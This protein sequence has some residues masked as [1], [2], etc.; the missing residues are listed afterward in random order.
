MNAKRG[1]GQLL[2]NRARVAGWDRVAVRLVAVA[3]L[4]IALSACGGGGGSSSAA[5]AAQS[6][7]PTQ[8]SVADQSSTTAQSPPAQSTSG[9]SGTPTGSAG[10]DPT[11]GSPPTQSAGTVTLNW[12]P[13]TEN[14]DGSALTNLAGYTIHY[15]TA[16]GAYT[17]SVT[18]NNP[19]LATY[20]VSSL[21]PGKYYFSVTAYNADGTQSPLSPEV[22]AT[23]N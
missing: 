11:T 12:S 13:P 4:G 17:Q 21:S 15:G 20:V 18:V 3:A 6:A 16:S 2:P 8:S 22:S 19:G 7:Q 23:V 10:S 1:Q 14:V 9:S 5:S